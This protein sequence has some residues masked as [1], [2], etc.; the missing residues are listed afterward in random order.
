MLAQALVF[1]LQLG[2][3][4]VLARLLMPAD[5]GV[6][7]MVTTFAGFLTSFGLNGFTEAVIQ[8]EKID[9]DLASNLFWINLVVGL[10]LTFGFACSGSLLALFY[11]EP[12]VAKVCLGL[13]ASIFFYSASVVH[14]ALLKRAMRFSV[15][16]MNDII[17]RLGSLGITIALAAAGWGYWSL[18]AYYVAWPLAICLGAWYLCR[19][20]P[21]FPRRVPGTGSLVRFAANVYSHFL[22]S[23]AG[24][25]TDNLL[26]W[27]VF[28]CSDPW[29]L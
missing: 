1:V 10:C 26:V 20:T 2:G 8:R 23:Y 24:S 22:V 3:T 29:F 9:H 16:S 21:A 17:S 7:T 15:L 28:S 11:H 14:L 5:F 6:I 13:S 25:N 27:M 18:V 12:R 4:M 19:W